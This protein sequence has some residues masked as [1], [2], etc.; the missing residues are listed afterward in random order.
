MNRNEFIAD[1]AY[2][3]SLHYA[4]AVYQG[5]YLCVCGT[6]T[7]TGTQFYRHIADIIAARTIDKAPIKLPDMY[8]IH[9]ED[10]Q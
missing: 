5:Y 1:A 10:N 9:Q 6:A 8:H 4:I 7:G 2:L 3:M